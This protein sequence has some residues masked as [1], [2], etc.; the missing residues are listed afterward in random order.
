M[1]ISGSSQKDFS[2]IQVVKNGVNVLDSQHGIDGQEI[3][4]PADRCTPVR[5]TDCVY[6]KVKTS[7]LDSPASVELYWAGIKVYNEYR[8]F[9]SNELTSFLLIERNYAKNSELCSE[10][11]VVDTALGENSD[12]CQIC[13]TLQ[14]TIAKKILRCDVFFNEAECWTVFLNKNPCQKCLW[15]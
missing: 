7:G 11:A 6:L 2:T 15:H 4:E 3:Y 9:K 5:E 12:A 1:T 14:Y 8:V 10:S 13:Q